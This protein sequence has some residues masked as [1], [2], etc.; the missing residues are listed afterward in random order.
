MGTPNRTYALFIHM[1]GIGWMQYRCR[2]LP[3]LVNAAGGLVKLFS[4]EDL[5]AGHSSVRISLLSFS[6]GGGMNC[7]LEIIMPILQFRTIIRM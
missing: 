6:T 2:D 7:M 3:T 4:Q 1:T 5:K